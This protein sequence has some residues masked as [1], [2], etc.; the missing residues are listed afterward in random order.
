MTR[1]KILTILEQNRGNIVSGMEIAD[2]LG[3]SRNAVW[4]AV[5][6]LKLEGYPVESIKNG[7]YRLSKKMADVLSVYEIQRYLQTQCLGKSMKVIPEVDSTNTELKRYAGSLEDGFVLAADRQSG[8]RGEG[9]RTFFSSQPQGVYFSLYLNPR[10]YIEQLPRL[11]LCA[12]LAVA[13]CLE[14]DYQIETKIRWPNDIMVSEKKLCGILT[15]TAVE[16]ETG[17]VEW[18]VVGIGVHVGQLSFPPKAS[19]KLISMAM[20]GVSKTLRAQLIAGIL[21]RFDYLYRAKGFLSHSQELIERYQKR[22]LFVG[23]ECEWKSGDEIFRA[24]LLGVEPDGQLAVRL[25]DNTI[26]ALSTGEILQ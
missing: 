12:A 20:L 2:L 22:L 9:G 5:N 14:S 26:R 1:Y 13:E 23:R 24:T 3:I 18:I 21:N 10:I 25:A 8:G 11:K 17:Q 7:G 15:E 19:N 4:K 6:G 16:Q